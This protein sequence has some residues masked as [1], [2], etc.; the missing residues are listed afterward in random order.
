MGKKKIYKKGGEQNR[1]QKYTWRI[2]QRR[3]KATAGCHENSNQGDGI[4]KK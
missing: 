2:E 4:A 1:R 3:D